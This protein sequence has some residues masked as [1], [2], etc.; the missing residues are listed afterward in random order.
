[1][2]NRNKDFNFWLTLNVHT[3][4]HPAEPAW[5][6]QAIENIDASGDIFRCELLPNG[7]YRI[8]TMVDQ[9]DSLILNEQERRKMLEVLQQEYMNGLDGEAYEGYVHAMSRDD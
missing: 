4:I 7:Y 9:R 5:L 8:W 6:H 3:A 2:S 1:M